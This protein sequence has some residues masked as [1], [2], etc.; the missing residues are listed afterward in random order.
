MSQTEPRVQAADMGALLCSLSTEE[1]LCTSS[2][3]G[4]DQNRKEDQSDGSTL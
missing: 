1:H 3:E 4:R 2:G